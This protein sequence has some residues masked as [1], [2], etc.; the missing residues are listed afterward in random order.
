[1]LLNTA[2]IYKRLSLGFPF[3]LI[4]TLFLC[5]NVSLY[6]LDVC[7][8]FYVYSVATPFMFC[9]TRILH[10]K[11]INSKLNAEIGASKSEIKNFSCFQHFPFFLFLHLLTFT[12]LLPHNQREYAAAIAFPTFANFQS[13]AFIAPSFLHLPT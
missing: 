4:R 5:T 10:W 7:L 12:S 8:Y 3:I 9:F 13:L 11:L 6:V 2:S 1:M